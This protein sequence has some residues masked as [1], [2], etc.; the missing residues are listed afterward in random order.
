MYSAFHPTE[1]N[2]KPL[3]DAMAEGLNNYI[4]KKSYHVVFLIGTIKHIP[5]HSEHGM[6]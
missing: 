2:F 6:A 4:A 1:F 3:F 5:G